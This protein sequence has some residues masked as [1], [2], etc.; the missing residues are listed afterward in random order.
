MGESGAPGVDS[1]SGF[2]GFSNPCDVIGKI[3]P[4]GLEP[5]MAR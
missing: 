5:N 3:G 2:T 4:G 1:E